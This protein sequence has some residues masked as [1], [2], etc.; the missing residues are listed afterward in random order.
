MT[1]E[2]KVTAFTKS[3]TW[4]EDFG[5]A[6]QEKTWVVTEAAKVSESR[7][8][9]STNDEGFELKSLSEEEGGG[10]IDQAVLFLSSFQAA[11]RPQGSIKLE[12]T[13]STPRRTKG[14]LLIGPAGVTPLRAY[15]RK[16]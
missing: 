9:V 1:D 3:I 16:R 7:F 2:K 6:K 5:L 11:W 14:A 12:F 10:D 13:R 4:A 15:S 8:I